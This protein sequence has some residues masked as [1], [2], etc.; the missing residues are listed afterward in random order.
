MSNEINFQRAVELIADAD[1]IIIAAG[2]GIGVD[3]GL[4]DFRSNNGFWKTYPALA[5]ARLDFMEVASPRTFEN[6]PELAWGFYGHRLK[7]YRETVPHEGFSI[8]KEWSEA[9]PMGARVYTS[10]VDG[11]FQKAGFSEETVHECHGS[12]HWMQCLS[13]CQSRLWPAEDFKPVIDS[14]KCRLLSALPTCP[15]C[16]G[17]ARP[18]ILMF[19]D[20]N[21]NHTRTENQR[22]NEEQWLETLESVR[23]KV[24]VIEMGAGSHIPSV[25]QFSQRVSQKYGGR[26]VRINPREFAVPSSLDVSIPMGALEALKGIRAAMHNSGVAC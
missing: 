9:A 14:E 10:N 16:E 15:S 8:L 18:N 5:S 20:W 22:L 2:A 19:G 4:P 17:L 12:I 3:S 24:V 7:M 1:A 11:A 21:W 26:I 25:R 23:V 13:D 6:D